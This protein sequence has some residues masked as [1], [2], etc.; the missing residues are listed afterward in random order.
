MFL[1]LLPQHQVL[2]CG[3]YALPQL[4]RFWSP[5][6]TKLANERP[7]KASIGSIR[8]RLQK[9]PKANRKAQELRQ[10]KAN[11]YKE[12]NDIFHYQSLTFLPKAIQT[13]LISSHHDNPLANYFG[14]EKFCK[15][16]AQKYYW[17]ILRHNVK[18]YVK[19]CNIC[20]AFKVV[21]HKSYGNLYL[22][23]VPTHP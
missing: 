14:I 4:W 7:Y 23:L 15:L 11:G 21:Y 20:L 6:W 2:I 1:G 10:Q 12:I 22:L 8:L 19:G 13:E 9:L 16:L 18:A 3:I 5:F 17:P